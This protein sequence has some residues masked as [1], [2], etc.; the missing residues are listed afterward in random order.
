M[1]V[2]RVVR[3]NEVVKRA[4]SVIIEREFSHASLGWVTLS[5]VVVSKDLQHARVF[6]TVLGD[7][8]KEQ[9]ALQRLRHAQPFV[10]AQLAH[11]VRMRYTPE[12]IFEIDEELK[13]ALRIDTLLNHIKHDDHPAAPPQ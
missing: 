1:S 11:T 13:T 3:L 7:A 2:E 9:H 8:D 5:R 4:L 6:F 10:R 12:L